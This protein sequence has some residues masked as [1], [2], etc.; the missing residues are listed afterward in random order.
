MKIDCSYVITVANPILKETLF[1][2]M[3]PRY[4]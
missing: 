2:C 1:R 4:L 3:E